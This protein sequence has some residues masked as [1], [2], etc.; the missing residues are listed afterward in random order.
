[1]K[2]I[3]YIVLLIGFSSYSQGFDALL[4]ASQAQFANEAPTN[5][6]VLA[7]A[8]NPNSE[9]NATTGTVA[10]TNTTWASITSSPTP[11]NGSYALQMTRPSAA[12]S[13]GLIFLSGLEIGKTYSISLWAQRISGNWNIDLKD[14]RG[15][16]VTDSNFLTTQLNSW[17]NLILTGEATAVNPEIEFYCGTTS[18]GNGLT[19]DNIVITE[20]P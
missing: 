7:N 12:V 2:K 18:I 1:M 5:L 11:Q 20:V 9:V 10:D 8:A 17:Y 16:A 4:I 19:V 14:W 3:L 13:R 6:Y 15:W